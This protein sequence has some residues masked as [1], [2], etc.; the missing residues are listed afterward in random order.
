MRANFNTNKKYEDLRA[1]FD[2]SPGFA[3]LYGTNKERIRH[4]EEAR[5][6]VFD[7]F[8]GYLAE[9]ESDLRLETHMSSIESMDAYFEML[10]KVNGNVRYVRQLG[11][12][13]NEVQRGQAYIL[14]TLYETQVMVAQN[15]QR[16]AR[17]PSVPVNSIVGTQCL[18]EI[19]SIMKVVILSDPLAMCGNG[20]D[21]LTLLCKSHMYNGASD[22]QAK[23]R[24]EQ[25]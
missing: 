14:A 24:F 6:D 9:A 10:S 13:L 1:F 17:A 8:S 4:Q 21:V 7:E 5:R 23:V 18:R 22:V 19:R 25:S 15:S 12:M 3:T 20:K 11:T 16:A 2:D